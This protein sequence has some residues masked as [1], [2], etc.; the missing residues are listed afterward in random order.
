MTQLIWTIHSLMLQLS[1]CGKDISLNLPHTHNLPFLQ[2]SYVIFDKL[3]WR[4]VLSPIQILSPQCT[5]HHGWYE[6]YNFPCLST[7]GDIPLCVFYK[8]IVKLN[9][10]TRSI[11]W[12]WYNLGKFKSLVTSI[13]WLQRSWWVVCPRKLEPYYLVSTL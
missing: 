8:F 12:F 11:H 13:K 7:G 5:G 9:I 6:D 3:L 4:C 10:N 2:V 1:R